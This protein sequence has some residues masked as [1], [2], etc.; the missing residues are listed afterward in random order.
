MH[1]QTAAVLAIVLAGI[2]VYFW[3][4][5]RT[6]LGT[7]FDGTQTYYFDKKT[8]AQENK[9]VIG[10]SYDC[11]DRTEYYTLSGKDL[12]EV[13]GRKFSLFL[14][15]YNEAC[16]NCLA[17]YTFVFGPDMYNHTYYDYATNQEISANVK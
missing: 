11:N 17:Y 8:I 14:N 5:S 3:V 15:E 1:K 2:G 6:L 9:A 13:R 16:S 4:S 10:F 7:C 12:K